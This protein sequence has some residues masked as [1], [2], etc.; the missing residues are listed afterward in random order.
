MLSVISI[1]HM[2]LCT[3][4]TDEEK[5]WQM[6][7]LF[8]NSYKYIYIHL[9]ISECNRI[10]VTPLPSPIS[11]HKYVGSEGEY[12]KIISSHHKHV[13]WEGEE[14]NDISHHKYSICRVRGWVETDIFSSQVCVG[15]EGERVGRK[16][17][18]LMFLGVTG[19]NLW[20]LA[21]FPSLTQIICKQK[22]WQYFLLLIV[23]C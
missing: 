11:H 16:W 3:V 4:N 8:V 13:G 2:L 10:L 6:R 9:Y 7:S 12:R 22:I 17:Y 5:Q 21:L 14:K 18:L 19:V 1:T 15:W 23:R 20:R